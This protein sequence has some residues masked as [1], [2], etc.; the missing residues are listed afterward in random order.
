MCPRNA[1]GKIHIHSRT[2]IMCILDE[3]ESRGGGDGSRLY[4]KD[5]GQSVSQSV[6]VVQTPSAT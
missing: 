2:T 5:T 4:F 3:L 6:D 1:D